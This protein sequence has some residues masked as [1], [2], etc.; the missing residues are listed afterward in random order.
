MGL[1]QIKVIEDAKNTSANPL[2]NDSI[3][4]SQQSGHFQGNR[5]SIYGKSRGSFVNQTNHRYTNDENNEE[6]NAI[7]EVEEEEDQKPIDDEMVEIFRLN[8]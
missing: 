3:N 5:A 4:R 1:T 2:L 7:E 8:E 6:N